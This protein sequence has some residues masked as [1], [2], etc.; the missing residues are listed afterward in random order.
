MDSVEL[1]Q[2]RG[3]VSPEIFEF[4]TSDSNVTEPPNATP[5]EAEQANDPVEAELVANPFQVGLDAL[6]LAGSDMYE[7][8]TEAEPS[9][10]R[11][12]LQS[13]HMHESSQPS[14]TILLLHQRPSKKYARLSLVLFHLLQ[15]RILST[16]SRFGISGAVTD[17]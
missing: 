15:L 13:D 10:K 5:T 17:W 4:L 3:F 12:R 7:V 11:P 8:N 6:L 2:L 14:A 1:E 9:V 16:V